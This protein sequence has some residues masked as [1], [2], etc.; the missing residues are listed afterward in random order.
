MLVAWE[1]DYG[2]VT[3]YIYCLNVIERTSKWTR[4][5]VVHLQQQQLPTEHKCTGT[6]KKTDTGETNIV[7][8]AFD[9]EHNQGVFEIYIK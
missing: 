2:E 1:L 4:H 9:I 8:P 6:L 5:S 3:Q 7:N